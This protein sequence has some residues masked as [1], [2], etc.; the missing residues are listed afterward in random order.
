[1]SDFVYVG[2]ELEL[3]AGA[4]IWK[5]YVHFRLRS[6]LSGDIL[7]V[8]AG[9]GAATGTFYDGTQKGWVCLEPDRDL[10]ERSSRTYLRS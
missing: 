5:S 3:F 10:A 6:Y 9:I 8:G 1:M 7:E 4:T 2:N